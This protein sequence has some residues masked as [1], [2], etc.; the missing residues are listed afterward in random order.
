MWCNEPGTCRRNHI[1]SYT[2]TATGRGSDAMQVRMQVLVSLIRSPSF[3]AGFHDFHSNDT[4][5]FFFERM[6]E[7]FSSK[8]EQ[9]GTVPTPGAEI[10]Q[11]PND[12]FTDVQSVHGLVCASSHSNSVFILNPTTRESIQLPHSRVIETCKPSVTY[13]FG[14]IPS[15]NK[16]KVLQILSFR[17]DR[18]GKWDLQFNT[19]TLG[20]DYWWRPLQVDPRHLPFDSLAYAFDSYNN[21]LGHSGSVCLNGAVHWI[22]EKQKLIVAFDFREET[23]KAIPLPEDNDQEIADYFDQDANH[24]I[25]EGNPDDYCHP[26]MVKVGG[27]VG[28]IVDMSWKRDEIMLWTLKDYHHNH[29]WVKETISLASEPRYLDC[30]RYVDALVT[31]HTGEF[32]LVHYFVGLTPGYGDGPPRS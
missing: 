31:V 19:F 22:Y 21:I 9:Q 24:Y 29:V 1:L 13:R 8:I 5:N 26:S 4:T 27:C 18:D 11:F 32:A 30:P 28:V 15:T 17:L 6:D 2:P 7:F 14:Y 12:C 10:F 20:R 25:G 16:Y 23:F 3:V